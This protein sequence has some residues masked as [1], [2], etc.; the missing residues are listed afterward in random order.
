MRKDYGYKICYR[1]KNYLGRPFCPKI[2]LQADFDSLFAFTQIWQRKHAVDNF[3]ISKKRLR[4]LKKSSKQYIRHF[5][6]YTREQ[7]VVSLNYYIRYPPAARDDGHVLNNPKLK[8]IPV[9]R[10]EVKAGIWR[11]TP[12]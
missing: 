6:T 10:S 11:E 3:R 1:E 2:S 5:L 12:F 8:I 4:R 7:A 9:S